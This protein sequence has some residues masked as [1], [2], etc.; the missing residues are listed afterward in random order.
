[1]SHGSGVS[2]FRG[3]GGRNGAGNTAAAKITLQ[4]PASK[5]P[6]PAHISQSLGSPLSGSLK[7]PNPSAANPIAIPLIAVD[8][9]TTFRRRR[10]FDWQQQSVAHD[11]AKQTQSRMR[12]T[13]ATPVAVRPEWSGNGAGI[14][15]NRAQ[16]RKRA[17]VS[18]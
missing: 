9:G 13:I 10:I 11:R 17:P 18:K 1:M 3:R 2:K 7:S 4:S 6:A 16:C 15:R 14:E 5:L 12:E 8:T